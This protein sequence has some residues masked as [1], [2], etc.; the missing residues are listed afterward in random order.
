MK[1]PWDGDKP[2]EGI[3]ERELGISKVH[4]CAQQVKVAEERCEPPA[5]K[6]RCRKLIGLSKAT[7]MVRN[8]EAS[9]IVL[10]RRYEEVEVP[11]RMCHGNPELQ[12]CDNCHDKGMTA[13]TETVETYGDDIVL[14]SR[15]PVDRP[16]D[17]PKN[18]E[19]KRTSSLAQKTPRSA[20]IEASHIH[21]AYVSDEAQTEVERAQGRRVPKYTTSRTSPQAARAARER[22]EDYGR[23]GREFLA[24]L[25]VREE[26]A[27]NAELGTGRRYDWGRL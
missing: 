20:T 9:W 7:L 1:H 27:D 8:G 19:K 12:P 11:C 24:G 2:R 5:G 21:R 6:C 15:K 3:M 26:P 4:S 18:R 25:I 13:V 10:A 22:I 23:L 14:V 16:E 17:A